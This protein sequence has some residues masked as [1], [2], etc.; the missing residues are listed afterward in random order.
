[1]F[2]K[3]RPAIFLRLAHYRLS[4]RPCSC[5]THV[6]KEPACYVPTTDLFLNI[7][8]TMFLP[9]ARSWISCRPY[10]YHSPVPEEPTSHVPTTRLLLNMLDT[11]FS[12]ICCRPCSRGTSQ[13]CFYD[14]PTPEY[15][16]DHVFLNLLPTMFLRNQPA[17]FLRLAYSWICYQPWL[18]CSW[19]SSQPCSYDSPTPEYATNYDWPVPQYPADQV[20]TTRM[21]L[22]NQPAMFLRLAYSW[23]CYQPWLTCSW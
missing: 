7:L 20:P 6:P 18:T 14:S 16:G 5:H 11:M 23:I 22:R 15:A 21:F 19:G 17:K 13:P 10:S 12:W 4:C 2:L 1:M 9:L 8:M 3:N